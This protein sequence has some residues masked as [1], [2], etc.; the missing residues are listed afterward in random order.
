MSGKDNKDMKDIIEKN[1]KEQSETRQA[2]NGAAIDDDM[3]K[4]DNL[5]LE[6]DSLESRPIENRKL[7][8]YIFKNNKKSVLG[9][10]AIV[11]ML[12]II[13]VMAVI[14]GVKSKERAGNAE[15]AESTVAELS[16][17]EIENIAKEFVENYEPKQSMYYDGRQISYNSKYDVQYMHFWAFDTPIVALRTAYRSNNDVIPVI[18]RQ[19][20]YVDKTTG[21]VKEFA[22]QPE[23]STI[24][25]EIIWA[26][27]ENFIVQVGLDTP[28][29]Y[30]I[31]ID[32]DRLLTESM[33]DK[34]VEKHMSG[35]SSYILTRWSNRNDP[36]IEAVSGEAEKQVAESYIMRIISDGIRDEYKK[37]AYFMLNG[38][39]IVITRD[40]LG[41]FNTVAR[42]YMM[43][44][45]SKGTYDF[46]MNIFPETDV[47]QEYYLS[48]NEK[49]LLCEYIYME[50]TCYRVIRFSNKK[51]TMEE[52]SEV[53]G[54]KI[55]AQGS[56]SK[57]EF[58]AAEELAK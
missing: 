12:V 45:N 24:M 55:I 26:S 51:V 10:I 33:L 52:I 31:T 50:E 17:I 14:D 1:M 42:Y 27:N 13:S 43:T 29:Y 39:P 21:E 4:A 30:C 6:S 18:Y 7:R 5:K 8:K 48:E 47:P 9:M 53:L 41:Q 37:Y 11:T 40:T 23:Y 20:Y 28:L 56:Y 22:Q 34:E 38:L 32:G 44:E 54:K 46:P 57:V 16:N 3:L 49:E 19:F 25:Q 36:E 58:R 2:M 15:T 35:M